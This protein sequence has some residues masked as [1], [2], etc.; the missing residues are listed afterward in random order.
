[1][2]RELWSPEFHHY[3]EWQRVENLN[4]GNMTEILTLLHQSSTS[5]SC[6]ATKKN[7]YMCGHTGT[8]TKKSVVV[9]LPI[10]LRYKP[11]NMS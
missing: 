3:G 2:E 9:M 8:G 11:H 6:T 5:T 10:N 4:L 7:T 1:M